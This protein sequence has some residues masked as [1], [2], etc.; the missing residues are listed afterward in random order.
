MTKT[1]CVGASLLAAKLR[2]SSLSFAGAAAVTS[3]DSLVSAVLLVAGAVLRCE[4]FVST[5]LGGT[6]TTCGVAGELPAS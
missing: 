4:F 1:A 6:V 5:T 2:C 3:N